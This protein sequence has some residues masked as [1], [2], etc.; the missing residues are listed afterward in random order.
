MRD[1]LGYRLPFEFFCLYVYV[2]AIMDITPQP[3]T[4]NQRTESD[5]Y[6]KNNH[7]SI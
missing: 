3:I 5:Q 7:S 4:L 1:N 6:H 2:D